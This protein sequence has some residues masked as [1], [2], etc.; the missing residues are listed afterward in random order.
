MVRWI[1][2]VLL[3]LPGPLAIHDI[4]AYQK[5]ADGFYR[6]GQPTQAGFE[7]LRSQGVRTVINLRQDDDEKAIVQSLG[8]HYEHL[9]MTVTV[10]SRIPDAAIAKYFAILN[11]RQNYP[12]FIHCRRGADRT[13][14][15][16]GFYRIAMQGWQ[17]Q[18]AYA[19]ARSL[20][21]RFWYPG[22]MKQLYEFKSWKRATD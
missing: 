13:G 7:F 17:G 9:P 10:A 3:L 12:I 15:M 21:M 18:K 2:F 19:E 20:G 6:G 11:D 8:M 22:L 4:P 5:I 16:V 1:T 14:A